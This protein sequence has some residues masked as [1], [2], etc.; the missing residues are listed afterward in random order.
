MFA[1]KL[2]RRI[3]LQ[4]NVL[5]L[6]DYGNQ[7]DNWSEYI[8]VWANVKPISDG[9]RFGGGEVKAY[10]TH[11]FQIR[12]HL[13]IADLSAVWRLEYDGRQYDISGVKELGRREGFEI[14]ATARADG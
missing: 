6:D 11:R 5:A 1:G 3:K 13:M 10:A 4:K 7:I 12:W 2:D 14:T 9:E 8:N